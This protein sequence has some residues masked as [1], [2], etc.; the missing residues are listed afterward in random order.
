M[1]AAAARQELRKEESGRALGLATPYRKSLRSVVL[2]PGRT[3][4][5]ASPSGQQ[6]AHFRILT[7]ATPRGKISLG[8]RAH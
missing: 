1:G 2:Q 5:V 7:I 6:L 4:T 8:K 3:R